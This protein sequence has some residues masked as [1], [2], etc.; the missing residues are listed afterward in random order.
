[1]EG[2]KEE[3]EEVKGG[4]RKKSR[5]G[6]VMEKKRG[7]TWRRCGG[8]RGKERRAGGHRKEDV[9]SSRLTPF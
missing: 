9:S 3:E 6:K 7:Q 1:M 5:E 4:W 8:V 2:L